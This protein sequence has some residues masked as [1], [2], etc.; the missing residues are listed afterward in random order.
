MNT[1]AFGTSVLGIDH[2]TVA[3]RNLEA[4]VRWYQSALGFELEE[5]IGAR[6]EHSGMRCAV[7]RAGPVMVLLVEGTEPGS[8]VSR[9]IDQRGEGV[10]HVAFSVDD[11]D[12]AVRRVQADGDTA[13]LPSI[14]NEGIRQVFLERDP[15]TGVRIELIERK[16]GAFTDRSVEAMFRILEERD[17]Y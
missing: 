9:F 1:R 4:S 7:M 13:T 11:L 14:Q 10:T 12:E 3:V 15:R 5:R 6:G 2:V 16:G 8:Q 17:L